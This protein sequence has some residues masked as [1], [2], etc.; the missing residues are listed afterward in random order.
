MGSRISVL[1]SRS[2]LTVGSAIGLAAFLYPFWLSAPALRANTDDVRTTE[3]PIILAILTGLC[4]LTLLVELTRA[5]GSGGDGRPT[6]TSSK[7]VALLGV[8]VAIDA[9]LRLVPTLLGASPIFVLIIFVGAVF[10]PSFGFVMGALTLLLS[11]FLTGGLGPFLPYQML[12]AGWVGLTAGWL[13]RL[14]DSRQR[15]VLLAIFG[16][17]WGL[18]YGALLNLYA[19]PFS[20]P[21][22]DVDAGLYWIPG[23]E[24]REIVSRYGRFY[25]VTS[26]GYDLF[27]SLATVVLC[28]AVGGPVLRL[29]ERYR[30]RFGWQVL[31]ASLPKCH[32]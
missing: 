1:N 13:P 31:E 12:G 2:L 6:L 3:A 9:V 14:E 24:V 30:E 27:R 8:L 28:L 32:R 10:G 4:L 18:L 20:A 11:A 15:L 26:L 22:L 25:L 16:A 19:W 21:G 29:L 17:I 7:A 5:G 23:L